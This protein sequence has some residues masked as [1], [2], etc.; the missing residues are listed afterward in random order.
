MPYATPAEHVLEFK[1]DG[2]LVCNGPGDP[3]PVTE[4]IE[5]LRRLAGKVPLFGICLGHQLLALALGADTCKLKFGHHG[6]NHPVLNLAD[7]RVEI[8]SQNH[9][10]AVTDQSLEKVGAVLTHRS[11]ND[12]S[13]E[14]FA[15]G[16]EP[17][18][19]VQYHPEAAPG[20]RDSAYLFVAFSEMIRTGQVPASIRPE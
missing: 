2:V 14:G 3:Q 1:P 13:V 5:T 16:S 11:L 8:T 12:S 9:G 18:F 17:I 6:V 19:A 10:F 15:H 4:T 20:P 7:G